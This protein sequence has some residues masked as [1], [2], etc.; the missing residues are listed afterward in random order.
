[1]KVGFIV[2]YFGTLPSYFQ[3]FLESCRNNT[4]FD[5]LLFTD[6]M[7]EYAYPDNV[8]RISMDFSACRKIVQDHFDFKITLSSPKKLCD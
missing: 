2:A 8:H 6:D 1:M 4:C 5:W 3:L 7:T